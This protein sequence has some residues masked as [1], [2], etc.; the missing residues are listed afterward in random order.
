MFIME[1]MELP[2]FVCRVAGAG[3]VAEHDRG[4]RRDHE[5]RGHL[6]VEAERLLDGEA[7][8]GEPER[9]LWATLLEA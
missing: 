2:R 7:L 6:P 5:G 4:V 9:I 1:S 3:G 8:G